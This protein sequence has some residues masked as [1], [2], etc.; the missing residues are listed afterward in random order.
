M[1]VERMDTLSVELYKLTFP[2]ITGTP[3]DL[4]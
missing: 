1:G 2:P 4:Q 3:F